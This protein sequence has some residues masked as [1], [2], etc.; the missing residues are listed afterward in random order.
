MEA[1]LRQGTH[2][3][4]KRRH[5]SPGRI[6]KDKNNRSL[7]FRSDNRLR[8]RNLCHGPHECEAVVCLSLFLLPFHHRRLKSPD[9]W[10]QRS[11]KIVLHFLWHFRKKIQS[12]KLGK[13]QPHDGIKIKPTLSSFAPDR[14]QKEGG[15]FVPPQRGSHVLKDLLFPDVRRLHRRHDRICHTDAGVIHIPCKLRKNQYPPCEPGK[16]DIKHKVLTKIQALI[17]PGTLSLNQ[18]PSIASG[19]QRHAADAHAL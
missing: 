4:Q 16:P 6:H 8:Q 1:P 7:P 12:A 17:K 2:H 18:I 15:S 13:Q 9:Q 3:T 11:K 14:S 19:P 10:L 5:M